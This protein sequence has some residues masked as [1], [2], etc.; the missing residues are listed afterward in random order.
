MSLKLLKLFETNLF[1]DC[2]V[3][4]V[5]LP[6]STKLGLTLERVS[7]RFWLSQSDRDSL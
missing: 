2:T 7:V 5:L 1:L 6:P 3:I 4:N